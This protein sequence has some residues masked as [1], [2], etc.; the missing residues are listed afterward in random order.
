MLEHEHIILDE[1][2]R[3][4]G[5]TDLLPADLAA[6]LLHPIE[7]RFTCTITFAN[8][9]KYCGNLC[10]SPDQLAE[11]IGEM[12]GDGKGHG[13]LALDE[14]RAVVF[15]LIHELERIGYLILGEK[16]GASD[17]VLAWLGQLFASML[18]RIINLNY[19]NLMTSGLH[20]QVVEDSYLRL[21][22]KATQLQRSEE[23]YRNLAQNLEVEVEKKTRTI[24]EAHLIMLQQEKLASIGQLAAGVAHE[25]NNP[26]GFVISNLNTLTDNVRDITRLVEQYRRLT[27][28]WN[29]DQANAGKI[30]PI[31]RIF[32]DTQ[33]LYEKLDMDF[34]LEDMNA[35]IAESMEGSQRVKTIVENLSDF[36]HPS[37]ETLESA[38]INQCL[39][40]TLNILSSQIGEHVE[41]IKNFQTIPE[42]CG[43]LRELN[44]AFFQILRNALQ[45]VGGQGV[46]EISTRA[47]KKNQVVVV[48][49][50]NGPG[51]KKG[52]LAHIF[53]P[54]FTT[55]EVG[56]GTGVGLHLAHNIVVKHH[57]SIS[58]KSSEGTGCTFTVRLPVKCV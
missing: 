9:G 48:I 10:G 57:G 43:Y 47:G 23:K 38:D 12:N 34:V 3:E 41:I 21:K 7:Q 54:F 19:K 32:Q 15:P 6:E 25:I 5:L 20:G 16:D 39:E 46:I 29:S 27:H 37:V 4:Y 52:D 42:V 2:D 58:V 35:L 44:Q 53:E 49:S 24:N 36:A 11:T 51:I 55:R 1:F 22:E 17:E 13:V 50:D 56:Q 31:D 40:T 18:N 30:G 8:G 26:M 28:E 45:A 33:N 14:G